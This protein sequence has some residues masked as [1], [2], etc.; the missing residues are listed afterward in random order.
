MIIW[1]GS[2][3]AGPYLDTGGRYDPA[4]DAWTATSVTGALEICDGF[5]NDCDG[6][7]DNVP[8]PNGIAFLGVGESGD[9][10]IVDWSAVAAATHYDLVRG[11]LSLL[12]GTNGDFTSATRACVANNLVGTSTTSSEAPV[13]GSAYWYLVRPVNC[14]GNGTYDSGDAGQAGSSDAE[15]N[16]SASSCP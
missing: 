6:L 13:S 16:A 4:A 15:I 5:D 9:A 2:G 14:G 11:D 3:P 10:G 12:P 7:A 8:S 1:G